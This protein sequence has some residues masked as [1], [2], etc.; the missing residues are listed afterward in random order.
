MAKPSD[1]MGRK[2]INRTFLKKRKDNRIKRFSMFKKV[3]D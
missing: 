3:K 1:R 2:E